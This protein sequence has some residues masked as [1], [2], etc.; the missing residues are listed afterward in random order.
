MYALLNSEG[1]IQT[2]PYSVSQLRADNTGTSFPD[3]MPDE[4]LADWNVVPVEP[5][6][7][8]NVT[9]AQDVTEGQPVNEAGSWKQAWIVTDKSPEDIDAIR[10]QLRAQAYREESDPLFFKAQRGEATMD[11]WQAKVA[12]IRAR[13][14]DIV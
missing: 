12:E 3:Q 11:E 1:Q 5:T 4:R 2:Y 7:Q 6:P 8:P 10:K 9:Y 13:Y 14:P